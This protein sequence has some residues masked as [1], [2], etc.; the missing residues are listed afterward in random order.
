MNKVVELC[1]NFRAAWDP[2]FVNLLQW[3]RSGIAWGGNAPHVAE[4][5]GVGENY[6]YSD[7]DVLCGRRANMLHK[8]GRD[9]AESFRDAPI[10]VP[11]KA[12]RDRLND[13]MAL[14]FAKK[15]NQELHVYHSQDSTKRQ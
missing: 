9:V 13:E 15:T 10:V 14:N 12:T 8:Q 5:K 6:T 7:F 1:K 3:I 11:E 4:Q 2:Q